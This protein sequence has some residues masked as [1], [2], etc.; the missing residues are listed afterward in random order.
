MSKISTNSKP[1]RRFEVVRTKF[2]QKITNKLL[3]ALITVNWHS[4]LQSLCE[5]LSDYTS[6]D[7]DDKYVWLIGT[8]PTYFIQYQIDSYAI[9]KGYNRIILVWK[10]KY[11]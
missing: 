1:N 7:L 2:N 4:D 6:S 8:D 11:I 3:E 9:I 10:P 5:E